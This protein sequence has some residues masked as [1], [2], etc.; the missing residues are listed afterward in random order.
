MPEKKKKKERVNYTTNLQGLAGLV[1]LR[2]SWI[3]PSTFALT[4][5]LPRK[6][7]QWNLTL[8]PSREL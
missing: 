6:L 2:K 5:Q 3:D 7:T 1:R 4:S 8:D